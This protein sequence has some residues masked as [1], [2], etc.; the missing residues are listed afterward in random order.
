MELNEQ[1]LLLEKLTGKKVLLEVRVRSSNIREV[2]YNKDS[3]DLEIKFMN[4]PDS[5][6]IFKNVPYDIYEGL[7]KDESKGKFFH[8]K[9]KNKF[10]FIMK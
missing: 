4:R 2:N 1:I 7:M 9:I 8:R 6:Y 3:K 10:G 5:I